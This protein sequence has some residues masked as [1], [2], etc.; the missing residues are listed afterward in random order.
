MFQEMGPEVFLSDIDIAHRVPSRQQNGAPKPIICKF[1]RWLANASVMETRQSAS[2]VNPSN[3]GLSVDSQSPS[4]LISGSGSWPA[5]EGLLSPAARQ[6]YRRNFPPVGFIQSRTVL[7]MRRQS[8]PITPHETCL[9]LFWFKFIELRAVFRFRFIACIQIQSFSGRFMSLHL[10]TRIF[11]AARQ[12]K[13]VTDLFC[14]ELAHYRDHKAF[15]FFVMFS[16]MECANLA[17]SPK[18]LETDK[19]DKQLTNMT[20]RHF[21]SLPVFCLEHSF[22][23]FLLSEIFSVICSQVAQA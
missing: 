13:N 6:I 19:H 22:I 10:G 20:R 8:N 7:L 4:V 15:I 23:Y 18:R 12:R 9:E 16:F 14:F 5:R 2:Q 1:V 17:T 21:C 3:I 11:L